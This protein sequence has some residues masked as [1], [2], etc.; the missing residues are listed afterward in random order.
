MKLFDGKV[1]DCPAELYRA[2]RTVWNSR[3]TKPDDPAPWTYQN[4]EYQEDETPNPN[5]YE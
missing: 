5:P 4:E 3:N 2:L 1:Q